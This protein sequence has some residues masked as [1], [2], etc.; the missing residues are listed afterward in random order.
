MAITE[1]DPRCEGCRL[2][3]GGLKRLAELEEMR[4]IA[5]PAR[6]IDVFECVPAWPDGIL[7]PGVTIHRGYKKNV[8][9]N[10]G[11]HTVLGVLSTGTPPENCPFYSTIEK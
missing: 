2:Y 10:P 9:T 6:D 4:G 7:T 8:T 11:D 5:E 3:Q 1:M